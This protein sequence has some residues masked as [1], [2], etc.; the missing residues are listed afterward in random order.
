[1]MSSVPHEIAAHKGAVP[2]PFRHRVSA[3]S[4]MGSP[5]C[6]FTLIKKVALPARTRCVSRQTISWR[7][8]AS[9]AVSKSEGGKG[10][11][12]KKREERGERKSKGGGRGGGR[13]RDR[14][15][16]RER[17]RKRR[18]EER[19]EREEEREEGERNGVARIRGAATHVRMSVQLHEMMRHTQVK[20]HAIIA[21]TP[22]HHRG[23][24]AGVTQSLRTAFFWSVRPSCVMRVRGH[25][26]VA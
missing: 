7:M 11:G 16:E 4:L 1:M 25:E 2:V 26:V 13:E 12:G 20:S 9:G 17:E 22:P 10:G 15:R 5:R 21:Q 23:G 6:D 18:G 8:S 19:R 14:E 3:R 24:E